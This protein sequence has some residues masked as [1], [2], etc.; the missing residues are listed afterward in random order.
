MGREH[1]RDVA[2]CLIFGNQTLRANFVMYGKKGPKL[3]FATCGYE[4]K[5]MPVERHRRS[6]LVP[7][8]TSQFQNV[9]TNAQMHKCRLPSTS[10]KPRT[11]SRRINANTSCTAERPPGLAGLGWG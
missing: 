3:I 1:C 2:E 10:T 6:L 8:P 11:M 5:S 4:S 7:L 9:R